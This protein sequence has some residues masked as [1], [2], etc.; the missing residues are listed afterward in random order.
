MQNDE[1]KLNINEANEEAYQK[2]FGISLRKMLSVLSIEEIKEACQ[3]ALDLQKKHIHVELQ[4]D[5]L[6]LITVGFFGVNEQQ[7]LLNEAPE[8]MKFLILI[9]HIDI[10]L[11]LC[12]FFDYNLIISDERII[13]FFADI[14]NIGEWK[15]LIEDE[16]N[17]FN[18]KHLQFVAITGYEKFIEEFSEHITVVK[19]RINECYTD[20]KCRMIF[21]QYPY[22]NQF[23]A[24]SIVHNNYLA[25]DLFSTIPDKNIPIIIVAAGPSLDKNIEE[26]KKAKNKALIVSVSRAVRKLEQYEIASDII[27]ITDANQNIDYLKECKCK[28]ALFLISG[29]ASMNIQKKY[30]GRLLF[31]SFDVDI[32]PKSLIKQDEKDYTD[33]GSV[34]TD[35][36][37]LFVKNGFSKFILVGQDLAF[38]EN[39][40]S[41]AD[42]SC[43]V[44]NEEKR[45]IEGIGGNKVLSRGDWIIFKKTYEKMLADNPQVTIVDATEG[46]ALI[47]GTQ[48]IG[49]QKTLEMYCDKEI[50]VAEWIGSI[51]SSMQDA[52]QSIIDWIHMTADKCAGY[53][54]RMEEAINTN[55]K[56]QSEW[57]S[58]RVSGAYSVRLCRE[59]DLLYHFFMEDEETEFIRR[60]CR[61][62]IQRYNE[63]ALTLERDEDIFQKLQLEKELFIQM[64]GRCA[65]LQTFLKTLGN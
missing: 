3:E 55:H 32:F 45:Y 58:G 57:R 65:E 53:Q 38:G 37:N 20:A 42:G 50:P 52:G 59:Y 49:L 2:R 5:L 25:E 10:F 17:V 14:N 13:F 22:Q 27:A 6:L 56:I 18:Y 40:V 24:L 15:E 36:V 47:K 16:I 39:E 54:S 28:N 43:E 26:L 21:D 7:R 11:L 33:T 44:R 1:L 23:H 48:V 9:P 8:N 4:R 34:A 35:I 29:F 63:E 61:Q 31:H 19:E 60:Y 46:G 62:E 12:C 64:H 51:S 41:H 30:N